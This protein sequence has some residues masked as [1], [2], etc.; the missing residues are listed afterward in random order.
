MAAALPKAL[1]GAEGRVRR[2]LPVSSV[3]C[4]LSRIPCPVSPVPYPLSRIPCPLAR[5]GG[6]RAMARLKQGED[7]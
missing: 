4:P 2:F 6:V 5:A 1:A 7:G 3:P